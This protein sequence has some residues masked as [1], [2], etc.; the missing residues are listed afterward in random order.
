M[1][2]APRPRSRRAVVAYVLFLLA[3]A[4]AAFEAFDRLRPASVPRPTP[5]RFL[6]A[7]WSAGAS[8]W[9]GVPAA[10]SSPDDPELLAKLAYEPLPFVNYGLKRSFARDGEPKR[11][12]NAQ[13]FRGREIELPKP[14]GR[15]R[16]VC[17][18]G[19]TTYSDTVADDET[20]PVHLERAL[21][22]RRPRIDLEVVNA[23][24]P[25]YTTADSLANLAF[26]CLDFAPDAIVVYHAANDYRPLGYRNFDTAYFHYRRVW[27]GSLRALAGRDWREAGGL[28][29]FVELPTPAD[30]GNADE[31][32]VRNG[33]GAYRR[34][35]TSILGIAK[36]H[37]VVPVIVSFAVGPVGEWLTEK[38]V[39]AFA[40]MN[41]AAKEVAA[42]HGA[43]FVDLA[44]KMPREGTFHDA[45][46]M[47]ARG[48]RIQG[49]IVAEELAK[50]LW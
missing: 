32:V 18:G 1:P 44:T 50:R 6:A 2:E 8:V 41:N 14:A 47:N 7:F 19:S 43:I 22:E 11:T 13:G 5:S 10:A 48:S 31:N 23:G 36:E 17:L 15:Y 12:S 25:S 35:L 34:N 16:I 21:R 30:N 33:F 4:G 46:H 42:A 29:A 9:S 3:L 26:R 28:N 38:K 20:Y 40:V 37:G 27:D 49:E 39:T 24:V 45:V